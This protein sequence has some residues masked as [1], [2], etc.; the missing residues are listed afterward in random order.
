M[1]VILNDNVKAKGVACSDLQ[2][3]QLNLLLPSALWSFMLSSSSLFSSPAHN[4]SVFRSEAA[5][6]QD[7]L[8]T[9]Q[10][11]LEAIA[12]EHIGTFSS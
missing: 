5:K 11:Q 6:T 3:I 7:L 8:R 10:T 9:E 1:K 4:F 2:R 12:G